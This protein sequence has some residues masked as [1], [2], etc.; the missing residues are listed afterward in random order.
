M[1]PCAIVCFKTAF[2]VL[3]FDKID[4]MGSNHDAVALHELSTPI[5]IDIGIFAIGYDVIAVRQVNLKE[6]K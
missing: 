4:C 2:V 6:V 1:K 3:V 5:R